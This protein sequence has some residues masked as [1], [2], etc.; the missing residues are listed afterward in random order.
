[1]SQAD[2][3]DGWIELGARYAMLRRWGEASAA[4]ARAIGLIGGVD[5]GVTGAWAEATVNANQGVVTQDARLGF[6]Q[7]L[8]A[9]PGD[10]RARYYLALATAQAGDGLAALQQWSD[11]ALE[12]PPGASWVPALRDRIERVA[13]ELGVDPAPYLAGPSMMDDEALASIEDMTEEQ[14]AAMIDGMVSNLA[15]RLEDEPEDVAGWLRLANAYRVQGRDTEAA[16]ALD[17]AALH[18][19]D[20]PQILSQLVDMLLADWR[21]GPLPAGLVLALERLVVLVPDDP[22]ALLFLGEEAESSGDVERARRYWS[23]LQALLEPGSVEYEAVGDRLD[24]LPAP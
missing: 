14:R 4:Y 20:D 6:E 10:P 16:M 2:D 17:Q 9:R 21:G 13:D 7:T 5:P 23:D 22:R 18:A 3:V 15:A 12:S 1:Q 24:S 11:L 8:E 19:P